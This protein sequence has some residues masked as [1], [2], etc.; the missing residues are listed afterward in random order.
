MPLLIFNQYLRVICIR[1]GQIL[2]W[3]D[4]L[5]FGPACVLGWRRTEG[6]MVVL[7]SQLR[8]Q[9]SLLLGSLLENVCNPWASSA[10]QFVA[11]LTEGGSLSNIVGGKLALPCQN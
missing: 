4:K 7:I 5:T 3:N 10:P 2:C 8:C 9:Y 11:L 1:R 6:E